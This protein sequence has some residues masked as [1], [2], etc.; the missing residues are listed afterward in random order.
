M[1]ADHIRF[2]PGVGI[3]KDQEIGIGFPGQFVSHSRRA[4]SRKPEDGFGKPAAGF[5]QRLNG[6]V[7]TAI[8]ADSQLH[9]LPWSKLLAGIAIERP[10]QQALI[11]ALAERNN[12][13]DVHG[14]NLT[15]QPVCYRRMRQAPPIATDKAPARIFFHSMRA[16]PGLADIHDG[17]EYT[18]G[19]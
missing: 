4:D 6:L 2:G 8:D 15:E 14:H 18:S 9:G 10:F 3:A 17:R 1:Q 7:L 12:H 19:S 16:K 11:A 5:G 13:G